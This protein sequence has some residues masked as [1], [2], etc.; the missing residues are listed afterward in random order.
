M[1]KNDNQSPIT[2]LS[3]PE[4]CVCCGKA[5]GDAELGRQFCDDCANTYRRGVL[6]ME[7]NGMGC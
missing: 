4:F 7:I 6:E 1:D 5:L 3:N 2:E